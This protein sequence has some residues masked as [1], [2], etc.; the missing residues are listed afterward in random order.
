MPE[1][2]ITN[3]PPVYCQFGKRVLDGFG[4]IAPLTNNRLGDAL[5]IEFVHEQLFFLQGDR[6]LRNVGY[7][8]ESRRFSEEDFGKSLNTLED[9]AASGYWLVGR[10]YHPAAVEAAL[11][12][13]DD[14]HYYSFFSN[15]CQ[16]WADRL[17]KNIAAIEAQQ[18]LKPPGPSVKEGV[19]ARFW[20]EQPPTVPGS[21]WLATVALLLGIGA[22]LAPTLAAQ[23][24]MNLLGLFLMVSGLSDIVYAVR[25]RAWSTL[26][27]A[28]FF[29]ALNFMAGLALL[30]DTAVATQWAGGIFGIAVAVHGAAR[31]LIALRSRPFRLWIG[32]FIAGL[33]MLAAAILLFTK[34]VGQRDV[35][36]GLLVASQLLLGGFST[37]WYHWANRGGKEQPGK[38]TG[39]RDSACDE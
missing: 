6:V 26:L 9:L 2:M 30:V 12:V 31:V 13:Q 22:M 11:E 4:W 34:T 35:L 1:S 21:V 18:S 25:G 5:N 38:I 29:A 3:E 33:G 39:G 7:N 32:S 36:F 10:P 14:G 27:S 16:D 20:K 8:E 37:L 19:D 17:R 28:L 15:Q 24:S 23:H